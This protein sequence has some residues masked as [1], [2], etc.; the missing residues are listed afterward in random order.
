MSE[1]IS[2]ENLKKTFRISGAEDIEVLKG[3]NMKVTSGEFISIMGASGS[4]KS[5]LLNIL[6]SIEV[7]TSGTVLIDGI[8]LSQADE[9]TLVNT[10]RFTTS[11]IYQDFN[12]LPYLTTL[13]NVMFPQLLLGKD[14]NSVKEKALNLLEKV[15]LRDYAQKH[16][17]DLSGGQRQRVG[18]ARALSNDPKVIF[19][20]EPTGNLDTKTGEVIMQLFRDLVI[21]GLSIIMVT[22]NIQLSK[23]SDKILI[24]K[25]GLLHR[26][27]E[28]E[29]EE[30]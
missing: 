26:E 30:I 3:I 27:E 18:I 4:G 2:V 9:K 21:E 24:L 14:E 25:E 8:D 13:E 12:L 7:P 22:H 11:I 29:Q 5:T 1:L 16:P 15:E 19:A 6:S 17:D 20:D 23:K 28:V 10:R